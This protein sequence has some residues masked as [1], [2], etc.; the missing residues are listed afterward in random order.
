MKYLFGATLI[1]QEDILWSLH[2]QELGCSVHSIV[3]TII[4]EILWKQ[5]KGLVVLSCILYH[6]LLLYPPYIS[7]TEIIQSFSHL[8][9]RTQVSEYIFNK[10]V[11][12]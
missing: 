11:M 8:V 6:Y 12:F 3:A 10:K 2:E 4:I 1:S 7:D 5:D 9:T